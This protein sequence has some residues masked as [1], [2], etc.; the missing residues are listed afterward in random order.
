MLRDQPSELG[1]YQPDAGQFGRLGAH[2][3]WAHRVVLVRAQQQD[4]TLALRLEELEAPRVE[5]AFRLC[6]CQPRRS[7]Q[8]QERVGLA[9]AV[10]R[11]R[12]DG[13]LQ[14]DRIVYD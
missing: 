10:L 5:Q 1:Q 12:V 2:L 6:I 9:A 14:A 4:E 3:Q 8:L 11:Q 13:A 7:Q